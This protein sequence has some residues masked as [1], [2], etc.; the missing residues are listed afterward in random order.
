M[1]EKNSLFFNY[2]KDKFA[3]IQ[4][5]GENLVSLMEKEKNRNVY[6]S[7]EYVSDGEMQELAEKM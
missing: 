2:D 1:D 6:V 3:L 7:W 4:A 5:E